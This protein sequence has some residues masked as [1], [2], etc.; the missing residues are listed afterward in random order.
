LIVSVPVEASHAFSAF[1]VQ[2]AKENIMSPE[3][4]S[5]MTAIV[6]SL[7]CIMTT[8]T[9]A[10]GGG[11]STAPAASTAS[12]DFSDGRSAIDRNDWNAAIAA[13]KK[14]VAHDSKNADAYNWLGYASRKSGKLDAAFEYYDT[15]L[16]IDPKHKGAHEYVGEAYLMAKK[17]DKAE[18]QLA[19]LAKLC[20]SSCEEYKDLKEA[21]ADYKSTN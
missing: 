7:L 18:E 13:F 8:H 3:I 2:F 6:F 5:I 21:I 4:R 16:K 10:A 12:S 19:V 11:G 1:P 9:F 14:V 17:P 15:A 20:N